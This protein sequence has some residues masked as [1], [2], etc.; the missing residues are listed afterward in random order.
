MALCRKGEAVEACHS[1]KKE[2][3]LE[4]YK[5]EESQARG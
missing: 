4:C 1:M 5:D 2:H 3:T